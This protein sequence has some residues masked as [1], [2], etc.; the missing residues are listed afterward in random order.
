M[1]YRI[2]HIKSNKTIMEQYIGNKPLPIFFLSF[3]KMGCSSRFIQFF[4]SSLIWAR[5]WE[6]RG[7]WI[8]LFE[9]FNVC[10]KCF[11]KLFFPWTSRSIKNVDDWQKWVGL[12]ETREMFKILIFDRPLCSRGKKFEKTFQTNVIEL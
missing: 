3:F 11:L 9:L 10:L 12:K 1:Q 8:Q 2:H 5:L 6:Q 4:K 7:L